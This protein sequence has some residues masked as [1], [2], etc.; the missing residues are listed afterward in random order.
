MEA[1]KSDTD[2]DNDSSGKEIQSSDNESN[3][4]VTNNNTN[5]TNMT[6]NRSTKDDPDDSDDNISRKYKT[7]DDE[8]TSTKNKRNNVVKNQNSPKQKNPKA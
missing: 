6:K 4:D 7:L 1:A 3:E 8:T 2:S 5:N